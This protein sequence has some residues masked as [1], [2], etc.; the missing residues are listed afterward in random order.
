[1]GLIIFFFYL[2][3]IMPK[4][5]KRVNR[6][7]ITTSNAFIL[8]LEQLVGSFSILSVKLSTPPNPNALM[9]HGKNLFG[10]FGRRRELVPV[11]PFLLT[12]L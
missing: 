11:E 2:T 3:M 4:Q 7:K 1:M 8:P 9:Q 12:L 5:T 10:F 6:E